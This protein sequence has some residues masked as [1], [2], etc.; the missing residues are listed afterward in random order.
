MVELFNCTQV[1]LREIAM[2]EA[3]QKDI[4]T[5]YALALRSSDHTDW[6][7]VNRAIINRWSMS[8]LQRIKNMAW[9]GK[10]F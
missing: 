9:S 3:K 6:I 8:G 7:T 1:L 10:C 4:S 2:P 5:T